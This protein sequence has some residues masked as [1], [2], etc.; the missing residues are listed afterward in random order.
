MSHDASLFNPFLICHLFC[1]PMPL[2]YPT[3]YCS[4][5]VLSCCSPCC[6][7]WYFWAVA[8]F[9]CIPHL[10]SSDL[11]SVLATSLG[12][13][14]FH[15]DSSHSCSMQIDGSFSFSLLS[16]LYTSITKCSDLN[17]KSA[18]IFLDSFKESLADNRSV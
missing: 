2:L 1:L 17:L 3:H 8:L 4:C 7:P 15:L 13:K 9:C 10:S 14:P 16:V 5:L 18:V 6:S 11:L 12:S